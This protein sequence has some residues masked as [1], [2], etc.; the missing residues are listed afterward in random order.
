MKLE[1]TRQEMEILKKKGWTF[2]NATLYQ[3]PNYSQA[4]KNWRMLRLGNIGNNGDRP[5]I[6]IPPRKKT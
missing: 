6:L 5:I 4:N 2:K 3:Q 1:I